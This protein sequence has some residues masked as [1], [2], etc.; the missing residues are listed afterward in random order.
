[1]AIGCLE[2][3]HVLNELQWPV[4]P[5]YLD[6]NDPFSLLL[7]AAYDT[8]YHEPNVVLPRKAGLQW[9]QKLSFNDAILIF[10]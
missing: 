3:S 4:Q 2:R 6:I 7:Q 5:C 1:M 9:C 10:E 8:D